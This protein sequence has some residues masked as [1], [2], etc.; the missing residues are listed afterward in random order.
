MIC[1]AEGWWVKYK[2]EDGDVWHEKV[3]F[4]GLDPDG[5]TA[6]FVADCEGVITSAHQ[7][8]PE[9]FQGFIYSAE[10]PKGGYPDDD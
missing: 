1:S 5:H 4:W 2:A 10:K 3:A 9:C 6:G 8:S 7:Y